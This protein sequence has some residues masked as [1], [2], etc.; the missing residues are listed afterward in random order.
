[1][2][3]KKEPVNESGYAW[4]QFYN[5][6]AIPAEKVS[7]LVDILA[8]GVSCDR[9]WD[10]ENKKYVYTL[11]NK[12]ASMHVVSAQEMLEAYAIQRLEGEKK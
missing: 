9:N 1:M 4:V 12:D 6:I 8:S 10:S 7:A 3:A 2:A 11:T 5:G